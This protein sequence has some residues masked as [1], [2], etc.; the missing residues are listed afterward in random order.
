MTSNFLEKAEKYCHDVLSGGIPACR[1]IKLAC[2]RQI[3]DLANPPKGYHFSKERAERICKFIELL[4][5]IKGKW[6][7]KQELIKLEPWQAF[8]FS[9][10][11]GWVN[12]EGLRRYRLVY[13]E[14]ARKNAK[15]TGGAATGLYLL[16]ADN[17]AGAEIY[18]AATTRDQAKIVWKDAWQ[19]V[20]R[21]SGLRKHFGVETFAHSIVCPSTASYF[22]ALSSEGGFQDGL[23][24]HGVVID[25]LHAHKTR[26]LYDVLETGTGSRSQPLVYCIT[27]AGSD[28]SGIAYE[29]RGY[30][31]KVLERQITDDSFFGLIY[32]LDDED[33]ESE[34]IYTNEDLWIKANPNYGVSVLP[35]DM[36]RLAK[37]AQQVHSARNNFKTKR[38]NIWVNADSSWMDMSAWDRCGD[39]AL[40]IE[41]FKGSSCVMGIDL[42]S[43]TD[44]CAKVLVF[45]RKID[46]V[47]HFYVFSQFY[48]P[49]M[50]LD[51]GR[52]DQYAGWEERG[53]IKTTSE[54]IID[55]DVI[56]SDI[57]EDSK[58]FN[59][60]ALGYDP[61]QAMQMIGHLQTAGLPVIEVRPSVPNFSEPMKS[62][63]A[64]VLSSKLHHDANPVMTWMISNVVCHHD[65]K[66]NIYPRKERDENKI[67]GPV[68]LITALKLLFGGYNLSSVYDGRPVGEKI[69]AV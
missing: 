62:L 15:S 24:I 30:L 45:E 63:E 60:Q 43:K 42:A 49:E 39:T 66:D 29:L 46:D 1:Y 65:V 22:K 53:L 56:E 67:D 58:V 47:P 50:A 5:H 68:A 2:Q 28:R 11:F 18:S 6:A 4:P 41:E 36:R 14:V 25:E 37:K 9:T 27:T 13:E 40:N 17:E 8:K 26:A 54:N 7:R 23:N 10:I 59:I 3:D 12:A 35:E 57:I 31:I 69:F 19:M 44:M 21:T 33:L 51:T 64:L 61:Y 38:L 20:Q 16:T 32:T 48:L 34:D 55:L 52:N